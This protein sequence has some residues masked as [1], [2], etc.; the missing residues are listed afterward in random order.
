MKLRFNKIIIFGIILVGLYLI[1]HMNNDN[2]EGFDICTNDAPFTGNPL[3]IRDGS[4]LSYNPPLNNQS[5]SKNA[6]LGYGSSG[7]SGKLNDELRITFNKP[8]SLKGLI[9]GGYGTFKIQVNIHN[10]KTKTNTWTN[11]LDLNKSGEQS[12]YFSGGNSEI[13]YAKQAKS[14][15]FNL[16][17]ENSPVIICQ[18]VKITVAKVSLVNAQFELYGLETDASPGYKQPELLNKYAK[19]FNENNKEINKGPQDVIVWRGEPNNS[20]PR[21]TVKFQPI[22]GNHIINKLIYYV[23]LTPNQNTWITSFNVSYKYNGSNITRHIGNIIGNSGKTNEVRHYFKYPILASEMTIK[24]STPTSYSS[25]MNV[26]NRPSCRVK[27]YGKVIKTTTEEDTL[28]AEQETYHQLIGSKGKQQTC[29]PIGQL[30]NKQAEI[31]QLCD[32]LEQSDEIEYEKKKIDSN[33]ALQLKLSRQNKEIKKLEMAI[34]KLRDT[35]NHFDAVEDRNKLAKF[36]YQEEMDKKLKELVKKKLE[37]QVGLNFNVAIKD[38]EA[39]V[40]PK[41]EPFTSKL[42]GNFGLKH[43]KMPSEQFYEE[44]IGSRFF[45]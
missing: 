20:D 32:A 45:N 17:V 34:K 36:K 8:I 35:N 14:S 2:V 6:I 37:K 1:Y 23:D 41:I 29:P 44:F 16:K 27:L 10:P 25:S 19:V 12:K 40:K 24:P 4:N 28:K 33:R 7:W 9:I 21:F 3:I 38:P 5:D 15:C 11:L 43:K 18:G 26:N 39:S 30:I 22:D 13:G 42:S 31:Q